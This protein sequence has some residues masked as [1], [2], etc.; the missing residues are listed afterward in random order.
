MASS[1]RAP[2]GAGNRRPYYD[3]S[4]LD[5]SRD[6]TAL[7]TGKG[8]ALTRCENAFCDWRGQIVKEAAV[9][10]RGTNDSKINHVAFYARDKVA[11]AQQDGGGHLT[12]NSESG[13]SVIDA[14]PPNS[15]VSSTVFNQKLHFACANQ[16]MYVYNGA[17][18][19]RNTSSLTS[20]PSAISTIQRR[21]VASGMQD[22]P[23]ELHFSRV[24]NENVMPD[25]EP[26]ASTDV[27]KAAII[28]LKNI[29]GTADR[30]VG[31]GQFESNRLAIFTQD[32]AIIYV[33]SPN[34]TTWTIDEKANIRTGC[35]S[36]RTI[37]QA[38]SD[39]IF[40]S[41]SGVHTLRRSVDNALQLY[42]VP[43]SDRIDYLYRSLVRSVDDESKI[44]AVWDQDEGQY[45]IFFPRPGGDLSN[46][47]TWTQHPKDPELSK[48]STGTTFNA[49][50]GAFLGGK[51]VF[52]TN[53]GIYEAAKVEDTEEDVESGIFPTA[54]IETPTLWHGSLTEWKDTHSFVLHATGNGRITVEATDDDGRA[55][56]SFDLDIRQEG[57]DYFPGVPL[58]QQYE[59]KFEHRYRGVRFRFTINGTGLVRIIGFVVN[60]KQ[61]A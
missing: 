45:H 44:S 21:L 22:R 49:R 61:R 7:D 33:L 32:Q 58:S 35:I 38:G 11:W 23:T 60:L 52:G 31:H 34:Y 13:H 26:I 17:G 42:S 36:H 41:R 46:R 39:L 2:T 19:S 10:K 37:A 40:C 6:D 29:I 5:A 53:G 12:L 4:G 8:Q 25:D 30:I 47:L 56:N 14:Y 15:V 28:D 50:C 59:R 18:W 1:S 55:I 20:G 48:W 43:M 16:P 54:V 27:T 51:L 9:F 24:D 3:F 57:D